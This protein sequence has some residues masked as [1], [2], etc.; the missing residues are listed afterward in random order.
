[1]TKIDR[2]K[3]LILLMVKLYCYK[4]HGKKENLCRECEKLLRY[5]HE[6]LDNCKFGEQK[7]SCRKCPSHCYKSDMQ[8]RIRKVMRFSGPRLLIHR[9]FEVV[10]Y[11][12]K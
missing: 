3:E 7:S 1:M 5:S 2:E 11:M 12:I 8:N 6:R 9:P 10:R 4:R